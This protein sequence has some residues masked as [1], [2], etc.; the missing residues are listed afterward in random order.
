MKFNILNTLCVPAQIYL[1]IEV[2][3]I[4]GMTYQNWNNGDN[5]CS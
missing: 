5:C 2:L 4:L 3:I 1:F